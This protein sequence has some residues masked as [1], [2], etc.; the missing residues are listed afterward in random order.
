MVFGCWQE[1][2]CAGVDG[3][4]R[5]VRTRLGRCVR[6][7]NW[8]ATSWGPYQWGAIDVSKP[9]MNFA[10]RSSTWSV[11]RN[12]SSKYRRNVSVSEAWSLSIL[13]ALSAGRRRTYD[14]C[15][16]GKSR[17]REI[18]LR[19]WVSYSTTIRRNVALYN[20]PLISRRRCRVKE[21]E[22]SHFGTAR[23]VTSLQLSSSGGLKTKSCRFFFRDLPEKSLAQT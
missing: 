22:L 2:R 5:C 16:L 14:A 15:I 1:D 19:G 12:A 3:S 20:T 8:S 10:M 21:R 23:L 4:E 18:R 6:A 7:Y 17:S 11:S 9:D 13:A